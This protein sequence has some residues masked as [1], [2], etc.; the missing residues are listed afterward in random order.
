R[1][2]QIPGPV[3]C[4]N[5]QIISEGQDFTIYALSQNHVLKSTDWGKSWNASSLILDPD[6]TVGSLAAGPKYIYASV[7]YGDSSIVSRP[8]YRSDIQNLVWEKIAD[9]SSLVEGAI[10]SVWPHPTEPD[11]VFMNGSKGL[12]VSYD[13][14]LTW[15]QVVQTGLPRFNLISGLLIKPGNPITIFGTI[16]TGVLTFTGTP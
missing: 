9:V 8:L 3:C 4:G 6:A 13:A 2:R 11:V 5:A 1:I 16:V 14:G 12:I 7:F 15:R 10:P